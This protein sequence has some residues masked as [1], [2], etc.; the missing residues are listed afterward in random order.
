MEG[1]KATKA[2]GVYKGRKPGIKPNEIRRLRKE[3]S[4][5]RLLRRSSG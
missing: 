2:R 3:V 5:P 1:I 4:A